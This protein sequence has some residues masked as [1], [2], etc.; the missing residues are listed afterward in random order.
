MY[1]RFRSSTPPFLKNVVFVWTLHLQNLWL[2][3]CKFTQWCTFS[4][5]YV[6]TIYIQRNSLS[7]CSLS[8]IPAMTVVQIVF[9]LALMSG[10]WRSEEV[11]RGGGKNCGCLLSPCH[12][13]S[14]SLS[15]VQGQTLTSSE[16]VVSG[17]GGAVTLSC[18]V[19]GVALAWLHWIRLKPEKGLEWI[20]R[21]DSGTGT[22]FAQRFQG[23]FSITKDTSKNVVSLEV[24]SVKQED[25]AVYYCAREPQWHTRLQSCTK[26][27]LIS[28][29]EALK[30]VRPF[31]TNFQL[32]D[33]K[34]RVEHI[35]SIEMHW[36]V[37]WDGLSWLTA[38]PASIRKQSDSNY[39]MN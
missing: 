33:E 16:P 38:M 27:P 29:W 1:Y 22:I 26:T 30:H 39:N 32:N 14:V 2:L 9:L 35:S 37:C 6:C 15:A 7:S 24:K 13:N 12:L 17:A 31:A 10:E 23:Q 19:E 3:K 20:G 21:I 8:Q 28:A 34:L 25:S 4:T 5:H 36:S 11:S 18:T